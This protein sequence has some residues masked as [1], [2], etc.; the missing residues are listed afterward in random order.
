MHGVNPDTVIGQE[1]V[2]DAKHKNI[3]HDFLTI[4]NI[5]HD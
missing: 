2:S 3:F 4:D 5:V 1:Q